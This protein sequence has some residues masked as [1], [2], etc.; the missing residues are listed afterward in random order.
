MFT[1]HY[2][3]GGD[4]YSHDITVCGNRGYHTHD[5]SEVTCRNCKRTDEYM[6]AAEK[7]EEHKDD[8][9]NMKIKL[10]ELEDTVVSCSTLEEAKELM[11]YYDQAG[12]KWWSGDDTL[13]Y[14]PNYGIGRWDNKKKK[15]GYR[16]AEYELDY[17]DIDYYKSCNYKII[18]LSE[19]KEIQGIVNPSKE[20]QKLNKESIIEALLSL[21]IFKDISHYETHKIAKE[22]ESKLK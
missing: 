8:D 13:Y 18:T 10:K 7:A 19:F 5:L 6:E 9:K 2:R 3:K 1:V 12:I 11:N 16:I 14:C 4:L 15:N 17:S 21:D 22:F 20:Q